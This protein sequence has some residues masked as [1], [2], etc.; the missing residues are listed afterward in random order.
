M[1]IVRLMSDIDVLLGIDA[2]DP[3][4]VLAREL[5]EGDRDLIRRLVLLRKKAGLTQQQVADRLGVSQPTVQSFERAGND[6]RL[7]TIRRYAL[8]IQVR[9]THQV[10]ID[11]RLERK[12]VRGRD[13]EASPTR[14]SM[15]EAVRAAMAG[16]L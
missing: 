4:Q 10:E 3:D 7:S 2:S 9:I 11:D 14:G 13:P 1:S 16:Y 12:M 15:K 6:P 8:A 5:V